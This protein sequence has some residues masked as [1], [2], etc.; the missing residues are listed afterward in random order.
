MSEGEDK[1]QGAGGHM[2]MGMGMAKK[3][4]A[5]LGK[6]GPSP[7]AMM[8]K[9]MGQMAEGG[10]APPPMMQMCMGMCAEMLTAIKRTSEMAAF[11]SPELHGLFVEWLGTMEGHAIRHLREKAGTDLTDLA[12]ALGI[13][14]ESAAYLL[15]HLAKR[16]KINLR[17]ESREGS[18]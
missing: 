3:M 6:G 11:A 1:A 17:A 18:E 10:Q 4:M 8:Q 5:Q 7:M 9:M 13:G 16:G 12:K 15:A 2:E 14:E